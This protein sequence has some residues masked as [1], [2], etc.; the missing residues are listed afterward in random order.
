MTA[1][2]ACL[3]VI[4]S[5]F[6]TAARAEVVQFKVVKVE[7]PAFGGREFPGVG[8][9]EKLIARASMAVDPADPHN[10]VIVD[11][12]LAPRNADGR[13]EFA[14]DVVILRPVDPAK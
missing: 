3:L 8:Q 12:G 10:A 11:V 13:V 6:A 2:L 7:S 1:R 14:T 5:F 4:A 9:Y